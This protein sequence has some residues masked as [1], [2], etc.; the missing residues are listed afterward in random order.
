MQNN[1]TNFGALWNGSPQYATLKQLLSTATG[2]ANTGD[3]NFDA[4]TIST[5]YASTITGFNNGTQVLNINNT[6]SIIVSSFRNVLVNANT[7]TYTANSIGQIKNNGLML[8]DNRDPVT[9]TRTDSNI[10]NILTGEG[11]FQALAGNL[12]LG[13]AGDLNLYGG[14]DKIQFTT[15]YSQNGFP[16]GLVDLSGNNLINARSISSIA[17]STG[18]VRASD[19]RANSLSS[20]FVSTGSL[21]AGATTADTLNAGATSLTGA[22]N[23]NNNNITSVG[24]IGATTGNFTTLTGNLTGNVSGNVTGNLTGNVVGN[25]SNT[26]LTVSGQYSITQTADVG[27]ALSNY[28]NYGTVNI[29]GKGGLGGIVNI[30]AD[31]ATPSNPAVTVSQLTAE[32]K[33]NYGL[34]TLGTPVGYI[35][36]GGL[37]SIIARQGLTPTPPAEVTSA[38]FANGE[39]DLTAYSY[40]VVPG[41]IKMSAGANSMYAGPISP[42]TGILGTN[43]I[44]GTVANTITAG[45]PPSVVPTFPGTN[46]LYGANGTSIQ[47]TLYV[48]NITNYGN[49]TNGQYSNLSIFI[50][51]PPLQPARDVLLSNV[52]YMYMQNTPTI[53]GAGTG[54]INNFSNIN[55]SNLNVYKQGY[56]SSLTVDDIVFNRLTENF[57]FLTT[58]TLFT[59]TITG[60]NNGTQTLNLLNTSSINISTGRQVT[61]SGS[62]LINI[63]LNNFQTNSSNVIMTANNLI[64]LTNNTGKTN[65]LA[66]TINIAANSDSALLSANL[67]DLTLYAG[68][69]TIVNAGTSAYITA[70]ITT[71]ASATSVN[72]NTPLVN[73]QT[74]I[75]TPSISTLNFQA[76]NFLATTTT[77]ANETVAGTLTAPTINTVTINGRTANFSTI[78]TNAGG[79]VN[80]TT[81][82]ATTVG[83]VA[84]NITTVNATTVSGTYGIITNLNTTTANLQNIWGNPNLSI[85]TGT[86]N[87]QT[88]APIVD[89]TQTFSNIGS[90]SWTV[91]AGITSIQVTV[92]GAGGGTNNSGAYSSPGQGGLVSGTLAVTPGQTLI[93]LVGEGGGVTPAGRLRVGG[94]GQGFAGT[95]CDGGGASFI[96]N[97]SNIVLVAAG[98]GGGGAA[99]NGSSNNVG[100]AGGGLV[101]GTG[102]GSDPDASPPVPQTGGNGGTQSAPGTAPTAP[103]SDGNNGSGI[104]GGA[105]INNTGAG[106]GGYYGGASGGDNPPSSVAAG[107]GGGGSS[108]VGN[109]TGT[110]VNTQG[111]GAGTTRNGSITITYA[112]FQ[113]PAINI[114]TGTLNLAG[115]LYTNV[116]TGVSSFTNRRIRCITVDTGGGDFW[117]STG[118]LY[119]NTTGV[120][121]FTNSDS[122]TNGFEYACYDAVFSLA[123]FDGTL[124]AYNLTLT[125]CVVTGAV[126]GSG[127]WYA[128][129]QARAM[130]GV[131]GP[132]PVLHTKWFVTGLFIPKTLGAN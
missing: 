48:D 84:G 87:I 128:A 56:I 96:L 125:Q 38:L 63:A 124:D 25:I 110:V 123:G 68:L 65:I 108:Y 18:T 106:G 66:S 24:T 98:G 22:L 112:G 90:T 2:L 13:A 45:S 122:P 116:L 73:V 62:N 93:M 121:N 9:G 79:S 35:P 119:A 57:D 28:G 29:S 10:T 54:S 31:V 103:S 6:S 83:A 1:Q 114:S 58:S 95:G 60:F 23:M 61:T 27:S 78:N 77:V 82:N 118:I 44:Y 89:F 69:S 86:L 59:S 17:V 3:S 40:G 20:I 41:L 12:T 102:G 88:N 99:I 7:F 55:T 117:D 53:D 91:P 111:G 26:N 49:I 71:V 33:G 113:P 85:S 74:H 92:R 42:I 30:T 46:Y 115:N 52:K 75:D 37:V 15:A 64:A 19:I 43:N 129:C 107:G 97:A 72:L 81:V 126:N 8:I 70:P 50:T 11:S 131:I 80:T 16:N 21:K 14:G 101:G 94:G 39:I 109:L 104:N 100:G 76:T 127:N 132:P 32:A 47:N 120:A 36:R 34:I 51:T 130:P 5:L 67:N 105:G 4:A